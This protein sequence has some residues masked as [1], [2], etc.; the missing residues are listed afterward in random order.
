MLRVQDIM[1]KDP[2]TVR[3]TDS[4]QTAQD[5]MQQA[6]I[7]RLVVVDAKGRVSGIVTDRDLRLAA[8]SPLILRERWQDD[9][10][11]DHTQVDACMTPDPECIAPTA[12]LAEAI[13]VLM[14]RRI[15]GL[16]V[17]QDDRLIGIITITDLL[18]TLA[19]ILR[20]GSI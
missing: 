7:R 15:S 18:R 17:V 1:T 12:P 13:D 19:F 5:R 4:L 14:L 9:M 3:A 8:N 11:M 10:L 20:S 6:G 2:I 16:P